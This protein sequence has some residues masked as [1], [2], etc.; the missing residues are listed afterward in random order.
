MNPHARRIHAHGLAADLHLA[1]GG[2][3]AA[4]VRVEVANR[5]DPAHALAH[6]FTGWQ[7]P[8]PGRYRSGQM[9]RFL[10]ALPEVVVR[11]KALVRLHDRPGS[12]WL[13]GRSGRDPVGEP[14]EVEGLSRTSTSLVCI[15]PGLDPSALRALAR[16][17]FG[18]VVGGERRPGVE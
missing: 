16:E 2:R 15:G 5:H 1:N 3:G 17:H 10:E 12:R 11:A 7:I 18:A 6:R 13:F 4:S 14:C 9:V 8:L